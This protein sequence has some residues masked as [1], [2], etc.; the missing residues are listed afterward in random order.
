[1]KVSIK[2]S[3]FPTTLVFGCW[4]SHRQSYEYPLV[5]C[6]TS[7]TIMSSLVM[8]QEKGKLGID[9]KWNSFSRMP[10]SSHVLWKMATSTELLSFSDSGE[11]LLHS[12]PDGILKL[13]ETDTGLLKQEY[14]PSS[15]L[16]ATCNCLSWCSKTRPLVRRFADITTRF[17][18]LLF[19][20]VSISYHWNRSGVSQKLLW[21]I[22]S[23]IF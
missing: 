12:S 14:T 6:A 5:N 19:V 2:Y 9:R 3:L 1:M 4:L 15:H 16:S 23:M 8:R 21:S 18:I 20:L 13:W 22:V 17:L 7:Q 11:Y 10:F